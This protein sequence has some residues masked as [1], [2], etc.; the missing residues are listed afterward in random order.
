MCQHQQRQMKTGLRRGR[1]VAEKRPGEGQAGGWAAEAPN[2][3]HTCAVLG[4]TGAHRAG[5]ALSSS[6]EAEVEE[7]VPRNE[8]TFPY[9]GEERLTVAKAWVEED[10]A[11]GRRAGEQD[12]AVPRGAG[13][14][15]VSW[16]GSRQ[17]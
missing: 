17:A 15:E 6:T 9:R 14:A 7:N 16:K 1:R 11:P 13:D 8:K 12:V 5:K 3:A 2:W 10:R 4:P